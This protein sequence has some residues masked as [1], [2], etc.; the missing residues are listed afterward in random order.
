[1]PFQSPGT[2]PSQTMGAIRT[3]FRFKLFGMRANDQFTIVE[4]LPENKRVR[5]EIRNAKDS[6]R[7]YPVYFIKVLMNGFE[8][9]LEMLEG[10][11]SKIAIAVPKDIKNFKGVTLGFDGYK[12]VY[13]CQ[14]MPTPGQPEPQPNVYENL[15]DAFLRRM[16]DS[17]K[18]LN[19]IGT[20]VTIDALIKMCE[21]ITPGD[22]LGLIAAGKSKGLIYEQAGVYKVT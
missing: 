6:Q 15:Q 22:A 7:P 1:M 9:D 20:Q 5:S 13:V 16:V 21:T 19:M 12:W 17:I 2:M 3:N 18:A 14:D 4:D 8:A 11:L 10:E